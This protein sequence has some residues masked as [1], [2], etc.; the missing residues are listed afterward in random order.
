MSTTWA[1][2]LRQMFAYRMYLEIRQKDGSLYGS[3]FLDKQYQ[4][5]DKFIVKEPR[6]SII[7][8]RKNNKCPYCHDDAVDSDKAEGDHVLG[9]KLDET[10]FVVPCCVS[11]NSSK[12]QKDLLEWWYCYRNKKIMNL[13]VDVF[14]I[15]IRGKFKLLQK[16]DSLDCQI[17]ENQIL[18]LNELVKEVKEGQGF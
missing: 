3:G 9:R 7:R 1:I 5:Y 6:N 13:V 14:K 18:M 8:L 16:T 10:S 11:C 12:S 2:W 17:S 4:N 15:Y